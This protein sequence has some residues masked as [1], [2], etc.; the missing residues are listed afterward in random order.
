MLSNVYRGLF[1]LGLSSTG[2]KLT[3]HLQLVP[4]SRQLGPTH[5]LPHISSS[6]SAQLGIKQ[7]Y[8]YLQNK[9]DDVELMHIRTPISHK[10]KFCF[11]A[12]E[13]ISYRN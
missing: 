5:P 13:V 8:L 4:R 1:S 2:V 12:R 3:T 7:L 9:I 10:R 6:R 11:V